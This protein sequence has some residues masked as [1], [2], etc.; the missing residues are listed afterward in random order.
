MITHFVAD[1][2]SVRNNSEG[3]YLEYDYQA[4]NQF[5]MQEAGLPNINSNTFTFV[6]LFNICAAII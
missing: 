3:D 6:P 2:R 5:E 4:S 1:Q